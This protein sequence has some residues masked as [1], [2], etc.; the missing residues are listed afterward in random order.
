MKKCI[1]CGNFIPDRANRCSCCGRYQVTDGTIECPRCHHLIDDSI[2]TCPFCGTTDILP[3][4]R[5]RVYTEN[6]GKFFVIGI[7]LGLCVGF[8]LSVYKD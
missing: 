8:L 1:R 5:S 6:K 3:R 7:A 2:H 4:R